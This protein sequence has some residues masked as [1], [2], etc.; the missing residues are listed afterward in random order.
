[1]PDDSDLIDDPGP[2]R[3]M[4]VVVVVRELVRIALMVTATLVLIAFL[5]ALQEF[6]ERWN[7]DPAPAVT[8]CVGEVPC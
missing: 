8:E 6:G 2:N 7:S 4:L 3:F 5:A 1:M